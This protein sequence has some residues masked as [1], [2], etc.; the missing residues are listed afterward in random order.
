M[1]YLFARVRSIYAVL[2]VLLLLP[3]SGA[4]Q[5]PSSTRYTL[6]QL[7]ELALKENRLLGAQDALVEE[8]RLSADQTR[9]WSGPTAGFVAGPIKQSGGSG[10]WAELSL[11]Q[12]LPLTGLP[13]LRGKLLE[14]ETESLRVQRTGTE[15]GVTLAVAEGAYEYASSRRKAAFSADRRKRFELIQ[16]YLAGRVFP[17]PQR[18]A[19]SRIV[20]NRVRNLVSDS[21]QSEAAYK[22]ALEKLKVYA[23]VASGYPEVQVPWLSGTLALDPKEWETKAVSENPELRVQRLGVEAAGLEKTRASRE[24]L[25]DTAVVGSYQKGQE[26]IVGTQVGVGLS[27]SFPSWNRNRSGVRSAEQRKIAEEKRLAFA[28]QRLKA[29]LARTLVEYE[30]ARQTVLKYPESV[31]TEL[32][33]ELKEADEG[34]RKGQVDL[35]TFLELD[36][37]AAETYSRALDA[38]A[39][40][41]AKASELLIIIADRNALAKL[42]SL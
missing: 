5:E 14:L 13:G 28:E 18:K 24:G 37:S 9:V 33:Q 25:P 12:P 40:L 11:A 34:F 22:A 27:L 3:L 30:A 36:G 26:D 19:E 35:L 10:S 6:P 7:V 16:S 39:Q 29:D 17:T 23:P 38:Q 21:V 15:V 20:S 8:K 42:S 41:A 1:P 4:A 32:D 31:L 2:A